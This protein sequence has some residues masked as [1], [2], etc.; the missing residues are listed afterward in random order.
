MITFLRSFR[1]GPF[2][3]FDFVA[4]YVLVYFLAPYLSRFFAM[5]RIRVSREQWLWLTLPISLIV[6]MIFGTST[7]LT[8]MFLDLNG[9]WLVKFIIFAMLYMSYRSHG[10]HRGRPRL[11]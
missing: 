7:P 11:D 6:H 8:K 5:F 4:S 9:G 10:R 1:F 2:A 3:I